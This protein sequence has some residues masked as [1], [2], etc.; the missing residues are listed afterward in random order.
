MQNKKKIY[1]KI[2]F[3]LILCLIIF[4]GRNFDRINN[5]VKKYQFQPF[6]DNNFR[7]SDNHFRIK[8]NMDK[9]IKNYQSCKN[10]NGTCDKNLSPKIYEINK[11]YYFSRK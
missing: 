10:K 9:I 2:K 7:I 6:L 1:S 4:L 8:N 11:R 3:L 5:E